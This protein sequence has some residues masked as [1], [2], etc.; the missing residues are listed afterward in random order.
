MYPD[1]LEFTVS[2]V[3]RLNV[4]LEE[5]GLTGGWQFRG[6][7]GPIRTIG[8]PPVLRGELALAT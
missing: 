5:V 3:P 2:D 4:A 1:H 6:V 7:G 8:T